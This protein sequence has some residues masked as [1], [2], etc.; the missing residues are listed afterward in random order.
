LESAIPQTSDAPPLPIAFAHIQVARQRGFS[1]FSRHSN[2]T[3]RMIRRKST[4]KRAT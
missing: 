1:L 4:S 3:T 2:E